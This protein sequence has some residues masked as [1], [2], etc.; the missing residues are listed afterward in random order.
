VN[1]LVKKKLK[2]GKTRTKIQLKENKGEDISRMIRKF[3]P[4][5]TRGLSKKKDP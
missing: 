4:S 2:M 3:N 5:K 1:G